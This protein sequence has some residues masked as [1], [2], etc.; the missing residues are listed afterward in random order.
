MT[1]MIS[2]DYAPRKALPQNP[3][4]AFPEIARVK[5]ADYFKDDTGDVIMMGICR[6]WRI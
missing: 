3:P 1:D 4:F 5:G 6:G 2:R